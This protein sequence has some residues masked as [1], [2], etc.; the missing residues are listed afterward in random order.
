MVLAELTRT[1]YQRQGKRLVPMDNLIIFDFDG[2]VADSEVL[3]N[4]VLAETITELGLPTTLDDAYRLYMGK[5]IADVI[6]SVEVEL[7]RPV[8]E[9]FSTDFQSRTLARFQPALRPVAGVTEYIDAF[10]QVPRCIASSSSLERLAECLRLLNLEE[11][12]GCHVYSASVVPRGKPHPDLFL[13][14][15]ER[16]GAAPSRTVVI[17]D[18]ASGV[19]AGIAA[20]MHVI[21][22]LAGSH[23]RDGHEERLKSAGAHHVVRSF[24]DAEPITRDLLNGKSRRDPS[25]RP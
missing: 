9:T 11:A 14:A 25:A 12:F 24:R 20:G 21:G 22:L 4:T 23:I 2:V 1:A 13:H 6:A 5:R 17:E 3:A 16:M 18:S 19:Q 10:A 15:A 8:P 7:G